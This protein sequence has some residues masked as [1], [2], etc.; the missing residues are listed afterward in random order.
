MPFLTG[1]G[2]VALVGNLELVSSMKSKAD[3]PDGVGIEWCNIRYRPEA[4]RFRSFFLA[5]VPFVASL[6]HTSRRDSLSCFGSDK[7]IV[8]NP[9]L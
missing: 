4:A 9:F 6:N 5:L 1:T 7:I 2:I 8:K 3:T